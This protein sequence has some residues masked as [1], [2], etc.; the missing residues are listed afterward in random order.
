MVPEGI[1]IGIDGGASSLKWS[2]RDRAGRLYHGHTLGANQQTLDWAT[3]TARLSGAIGEALAAAGAPAAEVGA[4]GMGL[5]G[6]D[7]APEQQRLKAWA[8][9]HCPN[10]RGCWVGNDAL[11]ALRQGAGALSGII[12]IAGTGS[13]CMGVAADGQI[14]RA[15]GWGAAL[16]DEGSGYWIGSQALNLA[17]QMADGRRRATPLLDGILDALD[18]GEAMELIPWVAG[19]DADQFKRRVAALTPRVLN[20]SRQGEAAARRLF[21]RALGHLENH[22]MAVARRLDELEGR[23]P[24]RTVVCAGGL[25]EQSAEISEALAPA[26]ARRQPPLRLVRLGEPA[27][28]GA[29]HLGEENG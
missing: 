28:L 11:P 17:C 9:T 20:L 4:L 1:A 14:L 3:Y 13:I 6:V 21:R 26:A 10:L 24:A 27:S 22:I 18:L 16:G 7:R 19:Q 2:V 8:R 15:G 12:L 29:L 5:S 23:A 25:F